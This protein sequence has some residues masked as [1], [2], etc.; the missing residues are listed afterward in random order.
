MNAVSSIENKPSIWIRIAEHN[1]FDM[2]KEMG[3]TEERF[4]KYQKKRLFR[5]LLFGFPLIVA[6]FIF[7]WWWSLA[8][9]AIS[10]F[11]WWNEYN[12]AK[13]IYGN[14][15]FEKQLQFSKFARM[16]IPYL[17][18]TEATLYSVFTRL[19][20]RLEEGHVKSSLERLLI[21][22]NEYPN[23]EV[24]FVRFAVDASGTDSAILFMTTL[25][26]FQQNTFDHSIIMELGQLSSTQLF[27]GVDEIIS[28]KL[29]KF[30]MYPTK[31]TMA[32][33]V[34]TLGYAICMISEA[35]SS[36]LF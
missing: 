13:K 6:A 9:I 29:R 35:F 24:P 26:D 5:S 8:G 18:Q 20:D 3:F 33:F 36:E 15:N 7:Q 10:T 32:S 21:E 17:L 22:M 23:S 4:I 30:S 1:L 14:F 16:L 31:L 27:E 2:C 34:I 12:R 11:L 25:Y 28:F 19:L